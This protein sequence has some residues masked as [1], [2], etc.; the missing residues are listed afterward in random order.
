[1]NAKVRRMREDDWRAIRSIYLAGIVTG[2]ATFETRT[3]SWS[4]W[5]SAHLTRPRLVAISN[6]DVLGWAALSRV[7]KRPVYAGV[8]EVSV[9]VGEKSRNLGIGRMLLERLIVES[10]RVGI[11]TLQ[12]GIF[13]ENRAS[14]SLHKSLGFRKVG[15]RQ[16]IGKLHGVWRDTVLFERRSAQVGID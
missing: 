15:T 7:S 5:N 4:Q 14:I 2:Q 16:R 3:P 1:M 9:Y 10:E 6:G 12:A 11:W 13:A 8:A